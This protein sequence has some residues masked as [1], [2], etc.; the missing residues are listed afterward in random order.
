MEIN[1]PPERIHHMERPLTCPE[2]K[3]KMTACANVDRDDDQF[4][5]TPGDI[6]VCQ[7]CFEILAF[8][9]HGGLRR[10]TRQEKCE[11]AACFA[12]IM[13]RQALL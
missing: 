9:E 7:H 2:C 3:G 6:T 8:T 10:T 4:I 12:D 1:I 13:E 11:F 5:P